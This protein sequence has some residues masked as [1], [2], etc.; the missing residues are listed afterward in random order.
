MLLLHSV[1]VLLDWVTKLDCSPTDLV[2]TVFGFMHL[3]DTSSDMGMT[4]PREISVN[5]QPL[6]ALLIS[7]A[8]LSPQ[9]VCVLSLSQILVQQR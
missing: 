5:L 6:Q 7:L 8:I 3:G 1:A 9:R 4:V 2:G